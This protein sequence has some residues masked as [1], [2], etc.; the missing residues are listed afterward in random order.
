MAPVTY[1]IYYYYYQCSVQCDG[2][3][4]TRKIQCNERYTKKPADESL[5]HPDLKP[6]AKNKCNEL[7]CRASDYGR[8]TEILTLK[9]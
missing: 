1:F 2:G 5:C 4:Q 7:K 9:V 8:P 6:H 3:I